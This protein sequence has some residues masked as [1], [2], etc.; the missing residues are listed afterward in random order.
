LY[1]RELLR[2][3]A[4]GSSLSALPPTLRAVCRSIHEN[5]GAAPT[6][7]VLNPHQDA[8]VLAMAD[9]LIPRTDTPGAKDTRVNEFIDHILARWY[10]DEERTTFLA[11][12]ADIDARAQKLCDK[13]FVDASADQ[14]S[15]ILQALG[16][17]LSR[18]VSALAESRGPYRGEAS[19]PANNF[20]LMFRQL[21]LTGYFTSEAGFSQQ[22]RQ[23]LIPG[24]Y[25]GCVPLDSANPAR[26]A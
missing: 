19:L 25:D 1:R 13:N 24:R 18:E 23:E 21:A 7:K 11:G 16:D 20:Y 5:L 26:G 3:L 9:L 6:L 15:E 14:Q 10:S 4:A 2:L 12:L 17:E 22:L 8:T